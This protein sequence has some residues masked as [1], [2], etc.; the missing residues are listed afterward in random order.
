MNDGGDED[1]GTTMTNPNPNPIDVLAQVQQ[2]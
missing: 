1:G 2:M